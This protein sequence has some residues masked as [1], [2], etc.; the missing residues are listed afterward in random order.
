M[1][2]GMDNSYLM[3]GNRLNVLEQIE[4][5]ML[6]TGGKE[7]EYIFNGAALVSVALPLCWGYQPSP[8]Y[9]A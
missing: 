8:T 3:L 2:N 7:G 5:K 4:R 1:L 6:L 9:A